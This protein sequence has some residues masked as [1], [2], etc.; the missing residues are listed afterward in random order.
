MMRR[1]SDRFSY[2]PINGHG[3]EYIYSER[4]G[5]LVL[6]D[7]QPKCCTPPA[8]APRDNIPPDGQMKP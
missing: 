8:P 4:D 6:T 2:D 7:I 1:N 5:I 3:C